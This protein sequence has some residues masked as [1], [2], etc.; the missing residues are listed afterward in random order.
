MVEMSE[1]ELSERDL[2]SFDEYDRKNIE[3]EAFVKAQSVI[4]GGKDLEDIDNREEELESTAEEKKE[5]KH[6][7]RVYEEIQEQ[8]GEIF[9]DARKVIYLAA[10]STLGAVTRSAEIATV[11]YTTIV[12][13]RDKDEKF[14]EWEELADQAHTEMLM[15]EAQRRAL[16]IAKKPV[17]YQGEKVAEEPYRSDTLLGKLLEG[18]MPEKFGKQKNVN[19]SNEGDGDINISINPPEMNQEI[20]DREIIDAGEVETDGN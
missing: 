12:R 13:W 2:K 14:V 7:W 8:A 1:H 18:K 4:L 10:Y 15:G 17:F 6:L 11:S 16:G 19:I 3:G 20:D 5:F 9:D